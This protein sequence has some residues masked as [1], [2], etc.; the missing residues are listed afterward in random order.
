M[1]NWEVTQYGTPVRHGKVHLTHIWVLHLSCA[2]D[3]TLQEADANTALTWFSSSGYGFRAAR[4]TN[5]LNWATYTTSIPQLFVLKL[6]KN[7]WTYFALGWCTNPGISLLDLS[8]TFE[9]ALF[10]WN[11]QKK[12]NR[13]II[14]I[15]QATKHASISHHSV[16]LCCSLPPV[17]PNEKSSPETKL[18]ATPLMLQPC[19]MQGHRPGW[20]SVKQKPLQSAWCAWDSW[21]EGA[22]S[23]LQPSC[24]A[25]PSPSL[26]WQFRECEPKNQRFCV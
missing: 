21:W 4:T 25:N 9:L 18:K 8:L 16:T 23:N 5:W 13:D 14:S 1:K 20:E 6:N 12:H 2:R 10:S 26:Q 11:T 22:E 19:K 24:Q 3:R 17:Q 15:Y 7:N